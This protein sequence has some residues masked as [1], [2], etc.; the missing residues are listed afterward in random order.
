VNKKDWSPDDPVLASPHAPHEVAAVLRMQRAGWPGAELMQVLG[1]RASKLMWALSASREEEEQA[2]RANR[3][4]H[5]A[6]IQGG[7]VDG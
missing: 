4:I 2:S 1:L 3:P 6:R 7:E 5:D